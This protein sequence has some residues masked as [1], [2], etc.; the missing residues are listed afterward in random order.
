[1]K[2]KYLA[3]YILFG[4][5][6]LSFIS[7]EKE[8]IDDEIT[9]EEPNTE[10][11]NCDTWQLEIN[12]DGNGDLTI[13]ST[14]G[15]APYSYIWSTSDTT[16]TISVS[17][18]GVYTLTI[19]DTEG[20]IVSSD[21]EVILNN[22]PCST[23]DLSVET[24]SIQTIRAI[25]TG[26]TLPYVYQWSTGDSTSEINV[27][28]SGT[29]TVTVV[30]ADGCTLTQDIIINVADPCNSFSASISE[31]SIGNVILTPT[32]TGG[33]QPYS[34]SWST[35]E[36]TQSITVINDGV[37]TLT[38]YDANGC[39]VSSEYTFTSSNNDCD[40]FAV[41]V[42][43]QP[44]GSGDIFTSVVGGTPAYTY[45]WST[46]ETTSSISVD[47]IGSYSV[48]VVDNIGCVVFETIQL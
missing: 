17:Q 9:E 40:G 36:T 21:V 33:N 25:V 4:L 23:F 13:Q 12:H 1:M 43:E 14:G 15:I 44:P 24:D 18:D 37:Y 2:Y 35:G 46:G 27:S 29:Y 45:V 11:V 5:L 8:N 7:C 47:T 19:T 6:T 10:V 22:T 48:S 31:E 3:T 30:D 39:V 38:V 28:A 20:C 41:I 26:G 42:A 34:Y 32:V 16:E